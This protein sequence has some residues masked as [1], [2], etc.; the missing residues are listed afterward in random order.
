MFFLSPEGKTEGREWGRVVI[1]I[2]NL[3]SRQEGME[4]KPQVEK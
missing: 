4:S 1:D 3:L 2:M